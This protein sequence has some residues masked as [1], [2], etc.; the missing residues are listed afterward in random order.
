[1]PRARIDAGFWYE[2]LE[3]NARRAMRSISALSET[4]W[5]AISALCART[6]T[7]SV[8]VGVVAI[9]A[10]Q[11]G[12]EIVLEIAGRESS[13]QLVGVVPTLARG[14]VVYVSD[15]SRSVGVCQNLV[16]DDAAARFIAPDATVLM[17]RT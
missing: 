4:T 16:S 13:W 9:G 5:T 1:M 17:T 11:R 14:P 12:D 7:R 15:A 3:V 10:A 8:R 2:R 6:T